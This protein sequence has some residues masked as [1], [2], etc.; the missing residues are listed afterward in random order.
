MLKIVTTISGLNFEELL[1][2]YREDILDNGA[3]LFPDLSGAELLRKSGD[4]F[5]SYLFEDFFSQKDAFYA[6]WVSGGQ[7]KAA[8]R[9]EPYYDGL[10]LEALSTAPNE[11]RKGYGHCLVSEVLKYLPTLPYEVVYSHIN[12][13][14][15]PSLELHKKCG[16]QPYCDFAKYIDGTVTQNSC[17]MCYFLKNRGA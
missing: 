9:M 11:R 1:E 16:F 14:N 6:L 4:S 3:R 15:M 8:L 7:Y 17:T 5:I 2:V 13:R 10:L 12:K